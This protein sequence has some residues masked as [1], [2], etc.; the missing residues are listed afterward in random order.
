[1]N[2]F[3]LSERLNDIKALRDARPSW[4][5]APLEPFIQNPQSPVVPPN[6][7]KLT[8]PEQAQGKDVDLGTFNGLMVVDGILRN[9]N[10]AGNVGSIV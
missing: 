2:E 6:W 10:V 9:V 1:M 7:D 4:M 3:D 5:L 8:L